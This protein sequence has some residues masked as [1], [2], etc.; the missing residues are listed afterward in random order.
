MLGMAHK[1]KRSGDPEE[2]TNLSRSAVKYVALPYE[3]W[4]ELSD[5]ADEED[6]SI[7][8]MARTV[9]RLGMKARKQSKDKPNV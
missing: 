2:Q 4:Q 3:L 7:S 8:W 1:K 5:M 6:R 9:I